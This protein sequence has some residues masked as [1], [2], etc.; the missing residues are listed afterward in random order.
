[1][2]LLNRLFS[3]LLFAQAYGYSNSFSRSSTISM[4]IFKESV[5]KIKK[6]LLPTIIGASLLGSPFIADAVPSGSRSGGSSFRSSPS[7]SYSYSAPSARSSTRLNS[8]YSTPSIIAAPPIF[9]P[10]SYG[11]GYGFGEFGM[12]INLNLLV[13]SW[14]LKL[15]EDLI[16]TMLLEGHLVVALLSL[17][18]K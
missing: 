11:Y 3:L 7:R 13:S 14:V 4:N 8:G 6:T 9:S 1:M 12:P 16:L 18:F 10:F 17:K 15:L 2:S 5:T